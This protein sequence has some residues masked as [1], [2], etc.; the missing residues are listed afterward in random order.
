[1]CAGERPMSNR[2]IWQHVGPSMPS[3]ETLLRELLMSHVRRGMVAR[4]CGEAPHCIQVAVECIGYDPRR[5]VFA[6][7]LHT[8][9]D[10]GMAGVMRSVRI[11]LVNNGGEKFYELESVDLVCGDCGRSDVRPIQDLLRVL[12]MGGVLAAGR[13]CPECG[14]QQSP[15]DDAGCTWRSPAPAAASQH[16]ADH[17]GG[18]ITSAS[19]PQRI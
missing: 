4:G 9:V 15:L 19:I 17:K 8:L 2:G 5:L 11:I 18:P 10:G 14:A 3:A 16:A 1:M 13:S 12:Y 7:C 6:A